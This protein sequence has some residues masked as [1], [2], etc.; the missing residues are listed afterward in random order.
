MYKK[1][2]LL[3]PK[4]K[5]FTSENPELNDSLFPNDFF[6]RIPSYSPINVN[7]E[8]P[9]YKMTY[10]TYNSKKEKKS[11]ENYIMEIEDD[12]KVKINNK[13]IN[14]TSMKKSSKVIQK[15]GG[16]REIIKKNKDEVSMKKKEKK[17]QGSERQ[18]INKE[19]TTN[20]MTEIEDCYK[21]LKELISNYTFNQISEIIIK[22]INDIDI[23]DNNK[24]IYQKIKKITSKIH[25]KETIPMMCLN[26]LSSKIPLFNNNKLSPSE[27][28]IEIKEDSN[29]QKA[30]MKEIEK[31]NEEKKEEE[32][33][34]VIEIG[35][36][37]E[38]K[39]INKKKKKVNYTNKNPKKSEQKKISP[40]MSKKKEQIIE[41]NKRIDNNDV[42]I[43]GFKDINQ[44]YSFGNH[45]YKNKNRQEIF[46][47][48]GKNTKNKHTVRLYCCRTIKGCKAIC[49]VNKKTNRAQLIGKHIHSGISL[50]HTV[51]FY[52]KYPTLIDEEWEHIQI[53]HIGNEDKIIIQN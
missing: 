28:V 43:N 49:I 9:V 22:I 46:S 21:T 8:C 51:E 41:K 2:K 7:S 35:D 44:E 11:F 15:I 3:M 40:R 37:I 6:Y 38:E 30:I 12:E 23:E 47:Y 10:D 26:I 53:I 31:Q 32:I 4:I 48:K 42:F 52:E 34:E 39:E 24:E 13:K 18:K 16:K 19:L 1:K 29:D 36:E 14:N 33:E 25:K 20:T 5:D 50:Q 17:N 45:Y 27:E